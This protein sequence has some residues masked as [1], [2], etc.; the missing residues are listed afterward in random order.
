MIKTENKE[1]MK[2][3][4]VLGQKHIISHLQNAISEKKVSHAYIFQGEEGS[5]KK[6]LADI[7]VNA[8]M[9]EEGGKEPCGRCKACRQ[10][11]TGNHPDVKYIVHE[12]KNITVDD[13]RKQLL[14][15]V[16]IKP[17]Q[18]P[19]KIYLIDEAEKMNE[20]A[21][22][23]LLKTIE[24]PPEYAIIIFLTINAEMLLPTIN[25]RCV[26]LNMRPVKKSEIKRTLMEE[27]GVAEFVA[28]IATN[29]AE[30]VPGKAIKLATSE[31]FM[32]I[33]R[34]VCGL[35]K[36][37]SHYD[38]G[39]R[40]KVVSEWSERKNE[41]PEIL[42]LIELWYRDVLVEKTTEGNGKLYFSDEITELIV[43][44]KKSSLKDIDSKIKATERFREQ[45][46][47]N[48]NMEVACE[49]FLQAIS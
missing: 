48:I 44:A 42:D 45:I 10:L 14:Y 15:D 47:A 1:C 23:A 40:Y 4:D 38:A 28:D 24:E 32:S 5:G 26:L 21:Q 11:A 49:L 22:N 2:F 19:Y 6:T 17:Y 12:K 39:E 27:H 13:I 18:G 16:G 8:L 25:S 34:E 7:F 43:Q 31:D 35:L 46:N 37:I 9:C 3:Q 36:N 20:A 33:K 41:L 29:F 30:G